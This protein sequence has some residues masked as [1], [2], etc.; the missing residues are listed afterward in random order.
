MGQKTQLTRTE[1]EYLAREILGSEE[2]A[3]AWLREPRREFDDHSADEL[4]E[5]DL[6]C[7][8]VAMALQRLE[9]EKVASS[10]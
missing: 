8:Q 2:A 9:N 10:L 3:Q 1:L 7:G 5:T 4:L 6:G